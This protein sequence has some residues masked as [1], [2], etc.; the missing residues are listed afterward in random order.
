MSGE[1]ESKLAAQRSS[2]AH[3]KRLWRFVAPYRG[4]V[5]IAL[6]AL[7]TAAGCVLALGQGLRHVIDA[8]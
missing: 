6:I 7:M 4:R 8:G 3:L 1:A 5:A 2:L